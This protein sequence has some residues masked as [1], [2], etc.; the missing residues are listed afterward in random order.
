MR[1]VQKEHQDELSRA[2]NEK[3]QL[4]SEMIEI[5][6]EYGKMTSLL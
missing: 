5:R 3:N 6:A 1:K 4:E 2:H